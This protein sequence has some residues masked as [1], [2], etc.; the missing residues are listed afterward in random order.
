MPGECA[1]AYQPSVIPMRE[2]WRRAAVLAIATAV[3][4]LPIAAQSLEGG[5]QSEGYGYH[6]H[7][8]EGTLQL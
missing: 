5:W 1:E 3:T 2:L 4:P 7:L 8:H 6:V